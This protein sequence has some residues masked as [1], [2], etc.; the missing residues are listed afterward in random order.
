MIL[1]NADGTK[2][3]FNI[4]PVGTTVLIPGKRPIRVKLEREP[5]ISEEMPGWLILSGYRIYKNGRM[6]DRTIAYPA[7]IRSIMWH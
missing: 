5:F 6:S 4:P 2:T 1:S 3:S 7:N